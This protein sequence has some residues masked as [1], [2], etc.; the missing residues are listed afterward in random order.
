MKDFDIDT[1][2]NK[3]DGVAI[4]T[5]AN[6]GLGFET[7]KALAKKK[8][9]VILACRNIQKAIK[10]QT[11]IQ[12]EIPAAKIELIELDLNSLHSVETFSRSFLS[13]YKRLDLLINNAGIMI[14][15]FQKTEDGFESQFGVNYLAHFA[16]TAHLIEVLKSTDNSRVV[17][18]SSIAHKNAHID[19]ENLNAE[20]KYSKFGAYGQSKLACLL[21]AKEL[22]HRLQK[23]QNNSIAVAAHPG[24]SNTEL[25][26]FMPGWLSILMKPLGALVAHKPVEGAKPTLYAA[27][28]KDIEGGDYTGPTGW[29]EMKGT[30]G[31]VQPGP[32]GENME[33]AKKLWAVSEKMTGLKFEV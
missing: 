33:M 24:V 4:V 2:S 20:K 8:F 7:A 17:A 14:P 15:P 5:G 9:T 12:E 26:R 6:T 28:G 31:K 27:L 10:A 13:R 23:A 30:P 19:L 21:F 22:N 3:P 1:I 11:E 18:L 32:Q 16:L 29:K 25:M